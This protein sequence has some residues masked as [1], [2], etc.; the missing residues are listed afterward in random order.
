MSDLL[1]IKKKKKNIGRT[2]GKRDYEKI[3]ELIILLQQLC[4]TI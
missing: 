1:L 4:L 2:H 3:Q